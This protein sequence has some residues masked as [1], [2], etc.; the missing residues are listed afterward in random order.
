M[1]VWKLIFSE[2][3]MLAMNQGEDSMLAMNQGE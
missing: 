3:S 2:D 1:Q